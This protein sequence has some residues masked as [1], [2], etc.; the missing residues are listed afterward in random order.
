MDIFNLCQDFSFEGEFLNYEVV[1]TG[2]INTT[3]KVTM[4]LGAKEERYLL[5]KINKNV[6]SH[7]ER[8]ME[9]IKSVNDFID[10]R[11]KCEDLFVLH[12]INSKNDLPYVIDEHGNFWR[13]CKFFDCACFDSPD[14]LF[15]IEEAGRAFGQFQYLL[16]GYD[17]SKLHVTIPNFHDTRKRIQAL[18]KTIKYASGSLKAIAKE[19]IDYILE[20]KS[21][22]VKLCELLDE[23]KIPLRVTHNDTKC[24]NVIFDKN[25]LKALAVIDLDTIMPG[26]CA[27]DFGDGARSICSTTDEDEQDLS[28]V[29]FDLE[30]FERFSKGYFKYLKSILTED[31]KDTLALSVYIMTL[32]LASRFLQDY[33]NGDVYF[34]VRMKNH[35]LIRARCQIALCKDILIKL[36]Q[37][38]EIVHKYLQ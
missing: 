7:P 8:I 22:A 1:T 17:A 18:E 19:E 13:A 2:N 31:E 21:I 25:T 11:H 16:N 4:Q 34:K 20:N 5:Q 14:D 9:N 3:Y 33:L 6:F 35:N 27:Y 37:M 24:N 28:L 26:L 23:G 36:D 15:V 30:R 38:N 29:K 32:E 10:H 12:F